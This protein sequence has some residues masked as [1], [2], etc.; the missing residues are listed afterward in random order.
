MPVWRQRLEVA[1][2]TWDLLT[3]VT[4][5]YIAG[6]DNCF[7]N[8]SLDLPEPIL[9]RKVRNP[10]ELALVVGDDSVAEGKDLSGDK[11]IVAPDRL[12]NLLQSSAK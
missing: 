8:V 2:S 3:F 5:V 9:P 4:S 11:E 1:V 10:G 7:D 6:A 12:T